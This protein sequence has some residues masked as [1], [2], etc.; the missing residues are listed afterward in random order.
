MQNAE[1]DKV[2]LARLLKEGE[3]VGAVAGRAGEIGVECNKAQAAAH[4]L[5]NQNFLRKNMALHVIGG[6][7]PQPRRMIDYTQPSAGL[8]CAE[9]TSNHP[10]IV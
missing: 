5:S 8:E 3:V 10:W 6:L 1:A 4:D 9:N 7:W 2:L